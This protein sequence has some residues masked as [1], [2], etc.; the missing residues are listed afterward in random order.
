MRLRPPAG[1]QAIMTVAVVAA[2]CR[3][4]VVAVPGDL[5][6]KKGAGEPVT[7]V[8]TRSGDTVDIIELR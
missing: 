6:V 1:V 5:R 8:L 7:V 3:R 4:R 2:S